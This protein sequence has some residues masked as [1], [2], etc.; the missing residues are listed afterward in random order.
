MVNVITLLTLT[1]EK[2]NRKAAQINATKQQIDKV[3]KK[4]KDEGMWLNPLFNRA[5]PLDFAIPE[6]DKS[7]ELEKLLDKADDDTLA[8]VYRNLLLI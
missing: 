5:C 8:Q 6:S 2:V 4:M 7:G 1:Q 3:V